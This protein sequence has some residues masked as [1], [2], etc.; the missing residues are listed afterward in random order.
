MRTPPLSRTDF[1]AYLAHKAQAIQEDKSMLKLIRSTS[2]TTRND[3][4]P[5]HVA[6]PVAFPDEM[7]HRHVGNPMEI[8]PIET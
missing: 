2:C 7:C 6:A 3:A 5:V 4:R 8:G 1:R